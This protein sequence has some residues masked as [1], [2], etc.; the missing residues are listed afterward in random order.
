MRAGI[1]R[2]GRAG[3]LRDAPTCLAGE[4]VWVVDANSLIFQVFHALPEMSSPRGEPVAAVFGFARDMLYLLE[5]KKPTYIFVAFDG[6][7]PTFRH[8]L[9]AEYKAGR[10]EMP[11]D[12][13][14]QYEHIDRLLAALN[15]PT[16]AFSSYEADDLLATIAHLTNELEG[17]CYIVSPDKDCRQLLTDRVKIFNVRKNVIYDAE[18][19]K[20]D[21]GV[22]PDQVVDF[23]ALVGDAV[24]NVPGVP[25]I[26]PKIASE[27]LQ[28]FDTLDT[29]LARADEL[30]KGK[31]KENLIAMRDRALLSRDLV[32]LDRHVPVAIDWDAARVRGV[33]RQAL[34]EL[35]NELGFRGLKEK[36]AALPEEEPL[37]QVPVH[38]EAIDTPE[39]LAWLVAQLEQQTAFSFDT[40]TTHLWPR[41]AEIVGYSFAWNDCQGYYVPVRAPAGEPCLDPNET[42]A[43]LRGVLENP[44]IAKV[45]QNLKYDMIVLRSAG[46]ELRG[47]RFDTMVASYLL[48]AGERNHN[49]DELALRYLRH[50]TTKIHELIGTGKD[51]KRMDEVPLAQVTHYAAE[52]ADV[53]WR[54]RAPLAARMKEAELEQLFDTVEMPLVEVL[55][56]LE[57]NGIKVDVELLGR[58]SAKYGARVTE[59][60]GEIHELAGREFNIGSP[61]QLQEI[62]F[63]ELK[64]PVVKRTKSGGS[65]DADVLEELARVHPLPAKIMEYRQYSKLKNTYVDALPQLVNPAT[66]RVHTSFNQVVAATG[67]L[68]SNDP[69]LQNIPIR[70]ETGREIRAA[71]LPGQPGWKLLAADYSQ[72]ELRVLAHFS[73][74]ETLCASFA[75]DEDIHARVASEVY[76]VP[77]AEVTSDMRRSAKAVNF[78]V[79]YGQSPFGLARQLNIEKDEA[80]RFINAYFDRYPGVE[81]FLALILE[82]CPKTGYVK[83][84]LGRRRAIRGIRRGTSRQRNLPERTAINTVIQG[85]AAD[86]IKL[87]MIHVHGRLRREN[88]AAK[89]LLQIHDELVFEVPPDE[90]DHV[91]QLVREEMAGVM[92]LSV[93]LKVDLKTGDN[94]ADCQ[95]WNM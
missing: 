30:P 75:R 15:V 6:P 79:I 74:D 11:T 21:W 54:L 61:K 33:N 65:T 48:D 77:L 31:R 93:P 2:S 3:D 1:A 42:A 41:W 27:Y 55:V 76:N 88:L 28:K 70:S 89:M 51:Q 4:T 63:D 13:V 8:D 86:L 12:L 36:F 83:T 44:D 60:E 59:L 39:R 95:E 46:I 91:A 50:R 82:E 81:K 84:I 78:G 40:E 69:N 35:F 62:L 14:P 43:A 90:L 87:A 85:S 17:E 72:I 7:E 92:P 49:L 23:Q 5:E 25:L 38:Y 9:Y 45:G 29:L 10:D 24:D 52:D 94:W 53:A 73:G 19:L 20:A 56:E 22:R 37:E 26:G 64:L 18:S 68:S 34:F 66:G 16:L 80:A 47:A 32:R 57:H 58:L 67:R 71:F